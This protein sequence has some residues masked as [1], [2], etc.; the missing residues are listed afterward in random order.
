MWK[1]V[2]SFFRAAAAVLFLAV[3]MGTSPASARWYD[4]QPFS[5]FNRACLTPHSFYEDKVCTDPN[6]DDENAC[7]TCVKDSGWVCGG[8]MGES[9]EGWKTYD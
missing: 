7:M 8:A 2:M 5:F 4:C 9:P 6:P 1:T 3:C